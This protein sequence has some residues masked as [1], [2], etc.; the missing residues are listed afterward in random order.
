M[1]ILSLIGLAVCC[2]VVYLGVSNYLK[3]GKKND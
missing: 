1:L 2:V 3:E